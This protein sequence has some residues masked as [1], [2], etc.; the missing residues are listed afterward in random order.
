[1]KDLK[2]LAI[3][4]AVSRSKSLDAAA[5]SLGIALSAANRVIE[6]IENELGVSLVERTRN[7][8]TL[9]RAG[10]AYVAAA[11]DIS[12]H[13]E[14]TG[15]PAAKQQMG[16]LQIGFVW[17]FAHGPIVQSL[18][19]FRAEHPDV[20]LDLIEDG[21]EALLRGVRDRAL[22][23]ALLAL[24]EDQDK[25]SDEYHGLDFLP[26]WEEDILVA[27]RDGDAGSSVSWQEML[28]N[29]LLCRRDHNW[30]KFAQSV[31]NHG[32]PA[33][34]FVEQDTSLDGMLGLVAA[35][36]G[37]TPVP[38]SMSEARVRGVRIV[39]IASEHARQVVLAFWLPEAAAPPLRRWVA[40]LRR[41]YPGN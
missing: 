27:T 9:T 32:G 2:G 26:L 11:S 33:L 39:P 21:P 5:A 38:Q 23:V 4:M 30:R 35:G 10:I 3:L 41:E 36:L 12:D 40:Q 24:D 34:T 15:A 1:M 19:A 31:K 14:A 37:W 17:S 28:A 18:A 6:S 20:R 25:L 16:R 22:D 7:G 29:P 13:G 8:L